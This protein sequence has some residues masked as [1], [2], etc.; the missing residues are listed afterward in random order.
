V[1][2]ETRRATEIAVRF[3][4]AANGDSAHDF[5]SKFGATP[6]EAVELLRQVV[7]AGFIPV[8]TFHPGSQCLKPAAYARHIAEA[9]RIAEM[10]GSSLIP[11]TSAAAFRRAIG[12]ATS[13]RSRSISR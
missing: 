7:A 5:S 6:E 4:L 9:A 8:L 13:R 2:G 11:S 10:P 12:Q 3:R 1:I